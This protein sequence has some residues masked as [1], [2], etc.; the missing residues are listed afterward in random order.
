MLLDFVCDCVR[1][2]IKA[3]QFPKFGLKLQNEGFGK[4]AVGLPPEWPCGLV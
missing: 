2:R 3:L 4:V 1:K